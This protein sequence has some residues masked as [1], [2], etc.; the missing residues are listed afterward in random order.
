M[1]RV[2][3][4]LQHTVPGWTPPALLA[5]ALTGEGVPQVWSMVENYFTHCTANGALE[6]RRREQAVD[7]MHALIMESLRTRFY[8]SPE[9][10]N[11]LEAIEHQVAHGRLPALSAAL[12]LIN[13]S[14]I[15][16]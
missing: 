3:H 5:S 9:V 8:S 12:Q 15:A 6:S 7:W 16:H 13:V 10:R 4:Y 2:I 11:R 14:G 1:K